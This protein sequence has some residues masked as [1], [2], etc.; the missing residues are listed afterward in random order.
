MDGFLAPIKHSDCSRSSTNPHV[1]LAS[2]SVR[3]VAN[4]SDTAN[5]SDSYEIV[6]Q[7]F[8]PL[9]RHWADVIV[10]DDAKEQVER[11]GQQLRAQNR[12]P[13]HL[14]FAA[15]QNMYLSPSMPNI[16]VPNWAY[17]DVPNHALDGNPRN[18]W[19]AVS[20]R[21]HMVF[22]HVPFTANALIRA[23]VTTPV[24]EVPV[25][26]PS[27]YFDVAARE[28]DR[29]ASLSAPGIDLTDWQSPAALSGPAAPSR[30]ARL[31]HTLQTR[32]KRGIRA[33]KSAAKKVVPDSIW[34]AMRVLNNQRRRSQAKLLIANWRTESVPLSGIVYTSIFDPADVRNNW[35]DLLSGFVW[36]MRNHADATLVIKLIKHD[37]DDNVAQVVHYYRSIAIPHRCRVVVVRDCLSDEQTADLLRASSYYFTTTRAEG[38]CLPLMNFLAA[39]RPGICPAHSAIADY[40]AADVGFV[41]ASHDEPSYW[42]QD[43]GHKLRTKWARLVWPSIV[44]QLRQSYHAAKHERHI[45][46]QL[47]ANAH[48]RMRDWHGEDRVY[49][50]L[51]Q[52]LDSVAHSYAHPAA[53][54]AGPLR[55]AA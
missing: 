29:D 46:D 15:C 51:K 1:L 52:A 50:L 41:I 47:A 27:A 14:G 24:R 54:P 17:P 45:Y 6:R 32:I 28:C 40:F 30:R 26:V 36:A 49:P 9:L 4:R 37:D 44:E 8:L 38:N 31:Q 43:G 34:L 13:I 3:S 18:D 21:C 10:V 33:G 11:I 42:P 5:S 2:T 22:A 7:L 12:R 16:V 23:G 35:T 55:R 53:V 19:V 25:P 48:A 20:N 39:G